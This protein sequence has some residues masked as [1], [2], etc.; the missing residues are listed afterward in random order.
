[1]LKV[2]LRLPSWIAT[3]I[4]PKSTGWLTLEKEVTEGITI[5]D[6]LLDMVAGYP[7]FR[8]AVYNPDTG[9]PT[10]QVNFVLNNRLLTYCEMSEIKLSDGDTIILIPLYT[11]G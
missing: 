11:G 1:M 6:F 2:R 10:E 4:E 7:G 3:V 9:L 5:N 8:G